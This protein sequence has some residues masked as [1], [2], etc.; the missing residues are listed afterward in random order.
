MEQPSAV[1]ALR[2]IAEMRDKGGRLR[3]ED[4]GG[5]VPSW[6][7]DGDTGYEQPQ[8][9]FPNIVWWCARAPHPAGTN[10]HTTSALTV[11]SSLPVASSFPSKVRQPQVTS[12]LCPANS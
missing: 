10:Q 9:S 1:H 5:G 12:P 3:G 4:L 11:V 6:V 8:Q 2:A 7:G